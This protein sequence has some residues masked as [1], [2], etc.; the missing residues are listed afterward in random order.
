MKGIEGG[1]V[2]YSRVYLIFFFI[3]GLY[4]LFFIV[5][6]SSY[7]D[8][9]IA[10]LMCRKGIDYKPCD[11][12]PTLGQ[13]QCI[14][15]NVTE[16]ILKKINDNLKI[17]SSNTKEINLILIQST[18]ISKIGDLF[19]D[20]KFRKIIIENNKNLNTISKNAFARGIL[21][22]LVI[23]DNPK[24]ND[25]KIFDLARSL[26]PSET[27]EFDN[28]NLTEVPEN[29]LRLNYNSFTESLKRIYLNNNKITKILGS[30]F[31]GLRNLEILSLN[32]NQISRI[33]EN[34]LKF[35]DGINVTVLLNNNNL[36]YEAFKGIKE[37][38]PNITHLSLHLENNRID[39]LPE[40]IFKEILETEKIELFL[41][42]NNFKCKN[43]T[44]EWLLDL[45]GDAYNNFHSVYC[46]KGNIKVPVTHLEK[47]DICKNF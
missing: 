43:C 15:K 5:Y 26:E 24:L 45:K 33:D 19:T 9:I 20:I 18:N 12:F 42:D 4:L 21:K 17:D 22:S 23:R 39:D 29:G 3:A 13:V 14:G 44:L 16:E 38:N 46:M 7:F 28:N 2:I 31:E 11:C 41:N 25:T 32:N 36:T 1:I 27:I 37:S 6:L 47:E 34:G 10:E 8:N 30:A 35:G 40:S